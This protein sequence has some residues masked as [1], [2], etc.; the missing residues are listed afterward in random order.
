MI[1]KNTLNDMDT[2]RELNVKLPKMLWNGLH[3]KEG[4]GEDLFIWTPDHKSIGHKGLK[5]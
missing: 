5:D 3:Q 4:N 2:S 1:N